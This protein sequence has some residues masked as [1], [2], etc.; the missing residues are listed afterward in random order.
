MPI[1]KNIP[2]VGEVDF[3]TEADYQD[4]LNRNAQG[5]GED[6]VP[7]VDRSFSVQMPTEVES[8]KQFALQGNIDTKERNARLA[9]YEKLRDDYLK[10]GGIDPDVEKA[11]VGTVKAIQEQ[12]GRLK[13][14]ETTG[15]PLSVLNSIF[16]KIGAGMNLNPELSAY[17]QAAEGLKIP[18]LR[19]LLGEKGATQQ[20]EQAA[21]KEISF[22]T[23]RGIFSKSTRP[24][25][26]EN[27]FNTIKATS[28]IDM[29]AEL[30]KSDPDF[31]G[32]VGA[33]PTGS[34]GA[35]NRRK[36]LTE[37]DLE[38][39]IETEITGPQFTFGMKSP[40]SKSGLSPKEESRLEELERKY[41]N[42]GR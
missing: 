31:L 39:L 33:F 36:G 19:G 16:Q 14:I 4:Y 26:L 8:A 38:K 12:L 17:Q 22:P 5:F 25:I 1:T 34:K 24:E 7:E 6:I 10:K 11:K 41:G 40:V 20:Q 23:G 30:E 21:A 13:N 37:E 42:R 27:I 15:D 3:D 35:L 9:T 32:A 2:G 29:R 28:G 18:V